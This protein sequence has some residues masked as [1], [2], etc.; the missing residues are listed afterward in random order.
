[1]R[2]AVLALGAI[3]GFAAAPAAAEIQSRTLFQHRAWEVQ[4]V[5]FE[6]GA[7]SCVAQVAR[8]G[9]T[10]SVWADNRSP[11][12]LQFYSRAWDFGT[13]DTAN[14][15]IQ[16]D[17]RAPWN[18]TNAELYLQS[19]LFNLPD[20]N[21]GTRFLLEVMRGNVLYLRNQRGQPVESYTLS[22]SAASIQALI[23]CVDGLG[24][25]PNPFR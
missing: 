11:V 20:D 4:V 25:S 12:K 17:R 6:D 5:R 18:L 14:L 16:I 24:T 10:F 15:V 21:T 9:V 1:M 13:G 3:L 2:W 7:V 23:N 8:P 22:G 19:V